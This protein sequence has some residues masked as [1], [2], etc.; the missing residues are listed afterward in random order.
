MIGTGFEPV[1]PKR[2]V[3][4]TSALD[5]SAT[6][7][8]EVRTRGLHGRNSPRIRQE[9]KKDLSPSGI[10]TR[11]VWVKTTYPDQTRLT[12]SQTVRRPGIKPGSHPWQGCI[13][14]LYYRRTLLLLGD[15]HLHCVVTGCVHNDESL[16]RLST[17]ATKAKIVNQDFRIE[18]R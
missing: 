1:P 3:P 13:L 12:G 18:F 14:S 6:Q 4:E 15:S 16:K 2:L 5:R 17:S 7:P 9:E 10:R 8:I 11:V